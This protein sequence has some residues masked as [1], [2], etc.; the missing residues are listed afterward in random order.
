MNV[1]P[2]RPPAVAPGVPEPDGKTQFHARQLMPF[3][4]IFG[5]VDS[6]IAQRQEARI[7]Q[8][9]LNLDDFLP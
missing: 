2:Q 6:D 9:W 1:R 8:S 5:P 3:A 4:R 7:V